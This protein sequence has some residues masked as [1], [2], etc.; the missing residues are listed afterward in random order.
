MMDL[1]LEVK[2]FCHTRCSSNILYSKTHFAFLWS[3]VDDALH[4]D[5]TCFHT[6][7]H[8]KLEFMEE[9]GQRLAIVPIYV[10]KM[11]QFLQLTQA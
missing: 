6:R 8:L 4:N 5:Q 9:K 1:V 2:V 11:L 7:R 3:L 10:V